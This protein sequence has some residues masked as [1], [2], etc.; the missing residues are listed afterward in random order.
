MQTKENCGK[1]LKSTKGYHEHDTLFTYNRVPTLPLID[2]TNAHPSQTADERQ[3]LELMQF[4][5]LSRN[6][7]KEIVT[8][9]RKGADRD[10]CF[11]LQV[12]E[13]KKF[14]QEDNKKNIS[15]R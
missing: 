6:A 5:T 1:D 10:K 3:L 4:N 13:V 2:Q 11:V 14:S 9:P 15:Q 8:Q 7:L 12:I